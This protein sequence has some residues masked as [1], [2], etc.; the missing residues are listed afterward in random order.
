MHNAIHMPLGVSLSL[1]W[2][3]LYQPEQKK[4]KKHYKV[5]LSTSWL[6]GKPFYY[7][8]FCRRWHNVLPKLK[9][10]AWQHK[11]GRWWKAPQGPA[12]MQCIERERPRRVR[13]KEI[14]ENKGE[15]KRDSRNEQEENMEIHQP[16]IIYS[17]EPWQ[18]VRANNPAEVN[19][20][21]CVLKSSEQHCTAS[22]GKSEW[23]RSWCWVALT[24]W[25]TDCT[26]F[27][28][29]S[30]HLPH[31]LWTFRQKFERK[32]Y[33]PRNNSTKELTVPSAPVW[34]FH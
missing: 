4:K 27:P 1:K 22:L 6:H 8:L 21:P 12:H 2:I 10:L 5:H 33:N 16:I 19:W 15:A 3:K 9:P 17:A 7:I 29:S 31:L 23:H 26:K 30:L 18:R 24:D 25:L 14:R 32:P 13:E 34:V 11:T 28:P 20:A